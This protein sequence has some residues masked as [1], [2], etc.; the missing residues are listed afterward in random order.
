MCVHLEAGSHSQHLFTQQ[1]LNN[2][3][4]HRGLSLARK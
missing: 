1:I 3:P 2:I 4:W